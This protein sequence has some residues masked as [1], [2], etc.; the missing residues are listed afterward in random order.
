VKGQHIQDRESDFYIV[1]IVPDLCKVNGKVIAYEISRD[2]SHE[3]E[4]EQSMHARGE[5]VVRRGSTIRGVEGNQGAGIHSGVS[6]EG[7]DNLATHGSS[8][9]HVKGQPICRHYDFVLMNGK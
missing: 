4:Y 1:N 7:G 2:L 8:T 9:V 6:L 5:P 3:L